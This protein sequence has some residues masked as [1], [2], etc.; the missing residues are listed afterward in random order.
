MAVPPL[1]ALVDAGHEVVLV[2]TGA[3]ARRGRR[4]SSTPSPVKRAATE[5]GLRVSEHIDDVSG[6]G[7]DLGVVVAFGKLLPARLLGPPDGVPMVNLHF[8]LLPR[9]RGAAPVERALLAGDVV[10][11]VCLM[12]VVEGLDSGPVFACVETPIGPRDTASELRGRLVDVGS[13]L[14]VTMLD[15][16]LPEP[17]PQHG[18]PTYAAKITP[19]QLRIDWSA[20]VVEVDRLVRVGGAWST[21]RGRRVKIL[22]SRLD[23][24]TDG[25]DGG[26]PIT[27]VPA[28]GLVVERVQ[29]EGRSPMSLTEFLNGIHPSPGEVFE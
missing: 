23:P 18:V 25:E 2:V 6:V 26:G 29:P 11:G 19:D 4:G 9:W 3:D 14:L 27:V 13:R 20:D 24:T 1:R 21:F 12:K 8:S 10:T 5:L 15:S 22:E 28:R 17:E 7:A 16:P